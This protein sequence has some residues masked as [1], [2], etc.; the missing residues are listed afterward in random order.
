MNEEILSIIYDYDLETA[1]KKRIPYY[2]QIIHDREDIDGNIVYHTMIL[3]EYYIELFDKHF[4][5]LIDILKQAVQV[6]SEGIDVWTVI[7]VGSVHDRIGQYEHYEDIIDFIFEKTY[8][9]LE[10]IN[11]AIVLTILNELLYN[12]YGLN[13]LTYFIQEDFSSILTQDWRDL[14]SGEHTIVQWSDI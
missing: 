5:E 13:N 11:K 3:Y 4:P 1:I 6:Q 10:P 9:S 7:D 14:I 8:P 2:K 12:H